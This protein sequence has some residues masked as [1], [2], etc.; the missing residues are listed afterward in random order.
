MNPRVRASLWRAGKALVAP[1]LLL[2]LAA[3]GFYWYWPQERPGLPEPGSGP[4]ELLAS[5]EFELALWLPY[6]HQ[7]LAELLGAVPNLV[8]AMGAAARLSGGK[9]LA[10]W[11]AFGPFAAP[12]AREIAIA[13]DLE[14]GRAAAA[15]RVYPM[16]AALAKL[17][18]KLA[19]N[20]WLAGGTVESGGRRLEVSWQGSLWRVTTFEGSLKP[21]A[22][23][24]LPSPLPTTPT[25][26]LLRVARPV[27]GLP[28]GLYSLDRGTGGFL[29]SNRSG[30]NSP[31]LPK[32]EASDASAVAFVADPGGERLGLL[33]DSRLSLMPR[34]VSLYEPGKKRW[35]LPA[36]KLLELA[37]D[38]PRGQVAGWGIVAVDSHA[39]DRAAALAPELAVLHGGPLSLGLWLRPAQARGILLELV[40]N[41]EKIPVLGEEPARRFRDM[42][43]VLQTLQHFER[44]EVV[45]GK[46]DGQVRV[47]FDT[48]GSIP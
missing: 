8:E 6:P 31:V 7:N 21:A 22:P 48:P 37:G 15:A 32:I 4:A 35:K 12:P 43:Q 47:E 2:A 27:R 18:G 26:A 11:P 16:I 14:G 45:V 44:V 23:S 24:F 34:L 41:L 29:L 42:A 9:G 1:L 33:F 28:A 36:E 39:Y 5:G 38:L 25:L 30:W 19:G 46:V 20:P 40:K 3:H 17:S 10:Q 13:F